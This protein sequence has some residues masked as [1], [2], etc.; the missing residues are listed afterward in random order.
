MLAIIY[1]YVILKGGGGVQAY[2]F[3]TLILR[4]ELK[5]KART[6]TR[7]ELNFSPV[8]GSVTGT[9]TGMVLDSVTG[10]GTVARACKM[11]V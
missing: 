6:R 5:G 2:N 3:G 7:K 9:Q 11:G 1:T 4:Y 8:P 10:T